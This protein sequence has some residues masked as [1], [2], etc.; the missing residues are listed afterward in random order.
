MDYRT[1]NTVASNRQKYILGLSTSVVIFITITTLTL[2]ISFSQVRK[3]VSSN[4]TVQRMNLTECKKAEGLSLSKYVKVS[5]CLY[6]NRPV[7][8]IRTFINGK[9]TIIGVGLTLNEWNRLKSNIHVI[10]DTLK[11]RKPHT[12]NVNDDNTSGLDMEHV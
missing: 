4:N 1:I 6:Q 8:D 7:V 12:L 3:N 2:S 11:S 5:A 10:D 9:A